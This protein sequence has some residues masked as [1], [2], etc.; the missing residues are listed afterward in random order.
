MQL[1]IHMPQVPAHRGL[2]EANV[3]GDFLIGEAL[4]E[5]FQDLPFPGRKIFKLGRSLSPVAGRRR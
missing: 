4:R 1:V 5:Q 2:A 3:L